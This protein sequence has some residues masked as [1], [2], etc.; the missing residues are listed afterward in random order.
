[1][2]E[3]WSVWPLGRGLIDSVYSSNMQI[4]IKIPEPIK[5]KNMPH[6]F[7]KVSCEFSEINYLQTNKQTNK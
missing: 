3:Q 5:K 2:L 6:D 4:L 7:L 1:M